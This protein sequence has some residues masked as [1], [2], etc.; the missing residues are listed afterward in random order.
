MCTAEDRSLSISPSSAL[1]MGVGKGQADFGQLLGF[2]LALLEEA[3]DHQYD[4]YPA[5]PHQS[6]SLST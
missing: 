5:G 6:Y 4:D 1:D 2:P 3:H